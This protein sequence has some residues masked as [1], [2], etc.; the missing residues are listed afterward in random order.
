MEWTRLGTVQPGDQIGWT[1]TPHRPALKDET[2]TFW[3]QVRSVQADGRLLIVGF[4]EGNPFDA[5]HQY[6]LWVRRG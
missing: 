1:L 3:R 6:R 4:V 2:P 5:G